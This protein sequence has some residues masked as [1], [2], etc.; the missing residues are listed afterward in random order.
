MK[1]SLHEAMEGIF[2]VSSF[3]TCCKNMKCEAFT[4][5]VELFRYTGVSINNSLA[6][7]V[8]GCKWTFSTH[9]TNHSVDVLNFDMRDFNEF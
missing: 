9:S 6:W 4:K 2:H 3:S 8:I 5:V 7:F 1:S